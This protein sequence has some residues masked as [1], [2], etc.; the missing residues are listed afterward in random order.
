[1]VRVGISVEGLTEE[2]FIKIVLTPYL[3]QKNIH[4]TPVSMNGKVNVAR[5][6]HELTRL[7]HNFDCVTTLYDFYGFQRKQ[8]GETKQ[9]LEARILDSLP[10]SLQR[11]CIPY[12]Q[13]Y[14]F[15]GLLFASP[16]AMAI[17]LQQEDIEP[18]AEKI[19]RQFQNNPEL[20]NDSPQTAPSKRLADKTSYRKTVHGPN[21]M[22]EIGLETLRK[23]CVGFNE[24]L[25]KLEACVE[26]D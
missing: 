20:I 10:A 4:I 2:R 11:K 19:L 24:W 16:E 12:I 22:Q 8:A 14:E 25:A 7:I 18:W 13:M 23:K 3:R 9:S 5:V 26:S 6:K 15:E 21:I 17:E 1:M